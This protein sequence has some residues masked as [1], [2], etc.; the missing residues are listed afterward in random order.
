MNDMRLPTVLVA[1]IASMATSAALAQPAASSAEPSRSSG[2]S[3]TRPSE[4]KA[5][6]GADDCLRDMENARD[7]RQAGHITEKEYAEQ[8]KMALTKLKRDADQTGAA[9]KEVNCQ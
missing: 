8:K 3:E 9:S 1:I 4:S 6:Y 7:A 5:S 2:S